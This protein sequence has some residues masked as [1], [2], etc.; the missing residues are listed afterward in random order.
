MFKNG[1]Y[2]EKCNLIH[3]WCAWKG[4]FNVRTSGLWNSYLIATEEEEIIMDK[5]YQN[6]GHHLKG[7]YCT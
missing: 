6:I 4:Y 5:L 1:G 2:E 7:E 3:S